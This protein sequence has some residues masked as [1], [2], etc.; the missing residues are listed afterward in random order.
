MVNIFLLILVGLLLVLTS[1][2]RFLVLVFIKKNSSLQVSMFCMRQ[3]T[4]CVFD[5]MLHVCE[6]IV[7]VALVFF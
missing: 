6:H 7:L 3:E 1:C 4:W 2:L 5:L